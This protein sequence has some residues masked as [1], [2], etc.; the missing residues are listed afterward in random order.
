MLMHVLLGRVPRGK[1]QGLCRKTRNRARLLADGSTVLIRVQE[2]GRGFGKVLH[3]M[4]CLDEA[5]RYVW[6]VKVQ[7]YY[8]SDQLCGIICIITAVFSCQVW[9]FEV[10]ITGRTAKRN[11]LKQM[12]DILGNTP[13]SYSVFLNIRIQPAAGELSDIKSKKNC[14]EFC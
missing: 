3:G 9:L 4:C 1:T 10:V 14:I 2:E 7:Q 11:A 6:P 5:T 8:R 12:F 13:Y